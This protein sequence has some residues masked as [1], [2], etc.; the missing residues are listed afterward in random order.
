MVSLNASPAWTVRFFFFFFFF[1]FGGGVFPRCLC[2]LW[3]MLE[4]VLYMRA[5]RTAAREAVRLPGTHKASVATLDCSLFI[6][7]V[8]RP[9]HRVT[10]NIILCDAERVWSYMNTNE[11]RTDSCELFFSLFSFWYKKKI[12]V[13]WH[14]VILHEMCLLLSSWILWA[15]TV[16][17]NK[18]PLGCVCDVN[19][20]GGALLAGS[21]I[22]NRRIT[23]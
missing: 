11:L 7:W 3:S 17:G 12:G 16:L 1:F 5:R 2:S 19:H 10:K 21:L 23:G 20:D 14:E 4:W 6:F 15:T 13:K 22:L 8:A 9:Y 18:R